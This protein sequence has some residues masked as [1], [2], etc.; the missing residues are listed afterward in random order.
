M[1]TSGSINDLGRQYIG[2]IVPNTTAGYTPGV[3]TSGNG[4][5]SGESGGVG[6]PSKPLAPSAFFG[7]PAAALFIFLL[8]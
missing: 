6:G 2:A 5:R 8:I 4:G 1:D 7:P 3:V